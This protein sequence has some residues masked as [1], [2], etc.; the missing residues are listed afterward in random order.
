MRK[1][2]QNKAKQ[3]IVAIAK[4]RAELQRLEL[5]DSTNDFRRIELLK[6]VDLLKTEALE[7]LTEVLQ[8]PENQEKV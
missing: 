1:Q 5:N 3:T 6:L 4:V 7:L 8:N 2:Q